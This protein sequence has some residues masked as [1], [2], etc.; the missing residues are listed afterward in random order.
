MQHYFTWAT[1][2]SKPKLIDQFSSLT[3]A[4]PSDQVSEQIMT[5]HETKLRKEAGFE[6]KGLFLVLNSWT[7]LYMQREIIDQFKAAQTTHIHTLHFASEENDMWM[8]K[9]AKYK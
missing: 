1:G 2:T 3:K 7:H 8:K 5:T 9:E 4:L 6:F